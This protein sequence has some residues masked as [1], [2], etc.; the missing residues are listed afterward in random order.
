MPQEK[1]V[2][3]LMILR[4]KKTV[5]ISDEAHHINALTKKKHSASEKENLTSW[6]YTVE[7]IFTSQPK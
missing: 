6:E 4:I 1:T 7:R 3:H 5:L 2:L